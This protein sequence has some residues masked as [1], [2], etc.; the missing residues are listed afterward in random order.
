MTKAQIPS[1]IPMPCP[2]GGFGSTNITEIESVSGDNVNFVDGFPSAYGA[3]SSNNGKFVTRK[4][5]NAIGNLASRDLFYHKCGGLNTFDPQFCAAIGGYPKGAVLQYAVANQIFEVM[6]LVEN[7]TI[8][9]TNSNSGVSGITNGSV[10]GINWVYCNKNI[11]TTG[12]IVLASGDSNSIPV[13]SSAI[14]SIVSIPANGYITGNVDLKY[15][16]SNIPQNGINVIFGGYAAPNSL[17]GGGLL[18]KKISGSEVAE[19]NGNTIDTWTLLS[20]ATQ[21]G[22]LIGSY[23][24]KDVTKYLTLNLN[25]P[26]SGGS[27]TRKYPLRGSFRVEAEDVIAIAIMASL[28]VSGYS[29]KYQGLNG[30]SYTSQGDATLITP[31]ASISAG[32][33]SVALSIL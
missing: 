2:F 14:M 3:P 26:R 5:M 30:N 27:S 6:S 23:T 7:N 16:N 12:Q 9:F 24:D 32:G 33:Y 28:Y 22:I 11:P 25:I 4:E 29:Y 15:G 17:V 10:D 1:R 20:E 31:G 19:L 18:V 8:D 21:S 13:G